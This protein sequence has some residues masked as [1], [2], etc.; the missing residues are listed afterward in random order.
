M[1]ESP[2]GL[3]CRIVL[4]LVCLIIENQL[5][6]RRKS[7]NE[8]LIH[9]RLRVALELL[10]SHLDVFLP[11]FNSLYGKASTLFYEDFSEFL[12]EEGSQHIPI[13]YGSVLGGEAFRN[14]DW[15]NYD[16]SFQVTQS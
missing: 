16:V 6:E 15:I 2:G 7:T 14:R 1:Y 13:Q 12:S 10:D 11:L 5:L 3:D 4:A 8:R 9:T